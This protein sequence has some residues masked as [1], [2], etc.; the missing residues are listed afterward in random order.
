MDPD[1]RRRRLVSL[2]AVSRDAVA[3]VD[4]ILFVHLLPS[5][6]LAQ[7]TQLLLHLTAIATGDDQQF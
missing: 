1:D 4:D 6:D 3:A 5:G 2:A 7:L